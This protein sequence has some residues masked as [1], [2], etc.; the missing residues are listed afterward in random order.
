MIPR[1]MR[2]LSMVTGRQTMDLLSSSRASS[3]DGVGNMPQGCVSKEKIAVL[4][5][6]SSMAR[7]PKVKQSHR[8]MS[9]SPRNGCGGTMERLGTHMTVAPLVKTSSSHRA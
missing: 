7:L 3:S 5:H 8:H 9:H 2:G 1:K 6:Y 4:A